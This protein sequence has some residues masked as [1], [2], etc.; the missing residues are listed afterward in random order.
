MAVTCLV[1][2]AVYRCTPRGRRRPSVDR[3]NDATL[4]S[5]RRRHGR[6]RL[7]RGS[8]TMTDA[9]LEPGTPWRRDLAAV[10]PALQSWVAHVLD[11]GITVT[12]VEAPANGMSSETV[13]FDLVG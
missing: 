4:R 3:V 2:I 13:L 6:R 11:D 5:P 8:A 10:E 1:F 12:N 7:I 9:E